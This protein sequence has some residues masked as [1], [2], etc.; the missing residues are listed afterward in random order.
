M[1]Q[2]TNVNLVPMIDVVFQLVLFFMVTSTFVLTPGI[3]LT[4][5]ES[6]SSEQVSMTRMVVSIISRNEIYLNQD[7]YQ[8]MNGL[9]QGLSRIGE[10]ERKEIKT[11]VIEGDSSVP[12][13]L[14]IDVL[15]TLRQNGFRGIS[16]KT[17][18]APRR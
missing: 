1:S 2:E 14:M 18:E 9:D 8:D 13:D 6:S 5:P 4:L 12:Y 16:L 15:D 10:E 7:R 11:V 17:R 3:K